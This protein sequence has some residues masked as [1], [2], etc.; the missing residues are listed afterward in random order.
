[1]AAV[2][3]SVALTWGHAIG[4]APRRA[5]AP[6]T[7]GGRR[8]EPVAAPVRLD[9]EELVARLGTDE[10]QVRSIRYGDKRPDFGHW[11]VGDVE[12]LYR[13]GRVELRASL[14]KLV[15]GRNDVV[16]DERDVHA[17][18]RELVRAGTELAQHPLEL[19]EAV[20]TRLDY[21]WQW[22]VPS[23]AWVIEHLKA[24]YAPPRKK[25]NEIVSPKG[26]RSLVF[27]Y[28]KGRRTIR[29]YDK[30]GELRDRGEESVH[31]VDT[32]LR[33]EIQERRRGKLRLVH[34]RGYSAVDVHRELEHGVASIAAVASRDVEAILTAA[35]DE[36]WGALAYTLGGLYLVEHE[37][38]LPVIRRCVSR[39]VYYLWRRRARELQLQ[40]ADWSPV[41]PL[42]ELV[43]STSLWRDQAAA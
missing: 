32:I 33:Y 3:D 1:M 28:D 23:V 14:P 22:E 42:Q 13:E 37:E 12:L 41:I 17:G 8:A 26:G 35:R 34:E 5:D 38:M 25:R 29:F 21:A 43:A 4:S 7:Q 40:V 39:R 20:P 16:L 2:I 9:M 11:K 27:G 15:A 36:W 30:V 31:D 6:R 10:G 18:L 24:S 19:R